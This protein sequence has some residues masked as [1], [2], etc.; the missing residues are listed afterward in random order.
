[1]NLP[2]R[3]LQAR[4]N[5]REEG[6]ERRGMPVIPTSLLQLQLSHPLPRGFPR[7]S[8]IKNCRRAAAQR[9]REARNGHHGAN[10]YRIQFIHNHVLRHARVLDPCVPGKTYANAD[11]QSNSQ[12]N[13]L[14][15]LTSTR[16]PPT[17]AL[18]PMQPATAAAHFLRPSKK[19]R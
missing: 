6:S 15:H 1:M 8:P 10:L 18:S 5:R 16:S 11:G 3:V 12:E 17:A 14:A 9:V 7:I 13:E 2:N 4:G 19:S